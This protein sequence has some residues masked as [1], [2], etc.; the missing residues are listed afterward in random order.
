MIAVG[1]NG[2]LM[3]GDVLRSSIGLAR[4]N[5]LQ[6]CVVLSLFTDRRAR[7]DDPLP[8]TSADRRGWVGDALGDG[9][10]W[11]SR[12]W[13]LRRAKETEETR[14][15]AEEYAREAL[16]WLISDT[17]ASRL[18]VAASWVARG[19]LGLAISITLAGGAVER[20]NLALAAGLGEA[21]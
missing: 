3:A 17:L 10:Q 18:D 21:A 16:Q 5:S 7:A 13:L 8:A 9:D 2:E 19:V 12:L 4:D 6:T 14:R 20:Y 15:R 11:G 1:W